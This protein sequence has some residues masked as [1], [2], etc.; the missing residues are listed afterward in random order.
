MS[1]YNFDSFPWAGKACVS[2]KKGEFNKDSKN[3]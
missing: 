1:R 3:N 2:S